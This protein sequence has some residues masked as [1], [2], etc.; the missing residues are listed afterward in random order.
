[1]NASADVHVNRSGAT[2]VNVVSIWANL[3][4]GAPHQLLL[5]AG[6][7]QQKYICT[8][9]VWHTPVN[10]DATSQYRVNGSAGGAKI[11][12]AAVALIGLAVLMAC[13]H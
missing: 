10:H 1:M 3:P 2:G 8:E 9:T 5:P 11:S 7:R 13:R 4:R 12:R 6:F